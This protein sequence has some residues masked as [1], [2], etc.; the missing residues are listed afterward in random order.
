MDYIVSQ[1]LM[2]TYKELELKKIKQRKIEQ[3]SMKSYFI[4]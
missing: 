1:V 4:L 3:K 2:L